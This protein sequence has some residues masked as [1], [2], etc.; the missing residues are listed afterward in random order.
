ML[1]LRSRRA[2][3]AEQSLERAVT[4]SWACAPPPECELDRRIRI[5]LLPAP[6][7]VRARL[8][9]QRLEHRPHSGPALGS[10]WPLIRTEPSIHLLNLSWRFSTCSACSAA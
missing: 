4:W 7:V 8:A 9:R 1:H 5:P 6:V 2:G 10:S 3:Q